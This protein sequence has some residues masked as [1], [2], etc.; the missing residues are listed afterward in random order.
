MYRRVRAV[1][2]NARISAA[3]PPDGGGGGGGGAA[4]SD[5][6]GGAG[7]DSN[8]VVAMSA[9]PRQL[10][11]GDDLRRRLAEALAGPLLEG[12][13]EDGLLLP[14]AGLVVDQSAGQDRRRRRVGEV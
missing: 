2:T 13:V 10:R 6:V 11:H 12:A 8:E 7:G 3:P 1:S 9:C 14:L 5:P 4:S